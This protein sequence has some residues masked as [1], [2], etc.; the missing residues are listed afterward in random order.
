MNINRIIKYLKQESDPGDIA[1]MARFGIT[2]DKTFGTRIPVLRRLAK[3]IGRDHSRALKLWKQGYRETM[4]LASMTEDI[5]QV[6][7]TQM[8][9]W[10]KKFDYWEICDQVCMNLFEKMECSN[11]K[12]KEW[13]KSKETFIK[14]AGFVLMARLAVSDKKQDDAA[15]LQF[16][17]LTLKYC[18]DNR[19]DAK[20]GIS[21]ALRQIGKRSLFLYPKALETA[22]DIREID[23]KGARWIASDVIRELENPKIMNR[24]S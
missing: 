11:L 5:K 15:F 10:V 20:K 18:T 8:N 2:P 16:L 22:Y 13:A 12:A 6:T 24:I 4:I 7:E 14:R 9:E 1:G 23:H 3:Q 19:I 21:W 17:P